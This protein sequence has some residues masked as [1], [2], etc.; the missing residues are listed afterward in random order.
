MWTRGVALTGILTRTSHEGERMITSKTRSGFL[1]LVMVA[2][3]MAP[4]VAS[5]AP[6]T[7]DWPDNTVRV[8]VDA[9]RLGGDTRYH[10]AVEI[11]R[12]G[13][14][15]WSGVDRVIIASGRDA[16]LADPLAAAGLCW[17]YD[18]P[19]LLVDGTS[20]PSVTRTAL[21][22]IVSANTTVT[23]TVIG[24]TRA[25]S[26]AC[27]TALE[28]IVG[29]GQVERP[30]AG[31]D[32]FETAALIAARVS[33]VASES[34]DLQQADAVLIANGTDERKFFDA[35][36]LSAVSAAT[37]A[38]VL[39]VTADK[40]PAATSRMLTGLDPAEVIAGGSE[41]V[42]SARTFAAVGGTDRWY[43]ADRYA[44]AVAVAEHARERGWLTA[45]SFGVAASVPDA[46]VGATY[47]GRNGAPLL[48]TPKD[49][50]VDDVGRYAQRLESEV[51]SATVFG[52][53][54][55]VADA[56]F[57]SLE[58]APARPV[59]TSIDKSG[60]AA[61]YLRVVIKTGVNTS[62][63]SLY[64]GDELIAEKNVSSY[65]TI[66]LGRY[67][68]PSSGAEIRVV[69]TNPEDGATSV[70]KSVKRLAY[71]AATSIVIDKSDF[72]LYWVKGDELVKG[73]PVAIG[74]VGMET[75]IATWKILAKYYTDPSSVYGPRKMRLFRKYG[76]SYVYTAYAI[77]GTNE[78]WVIGT[79][80][81]HGCI[82]MY[83]SDV[84]ELFPQVPLGT[85]VQTRD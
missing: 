45:P 57:K 9:T 63:C 68:V 27:V 73:Y 72:R 59:I 33:E 53:S 21:N 83:N 11:A 39:F 36:A 42:I 52:S 10:T 79:K 55:A 78:P 34:A 32:R 84:L 3:L 56:V 24:S 41:T 81:S 80:A 58:G 43:G 37:G 31:Y 28:G 18:A 6:R 48:Y 44:T 4:G 82:R 49:T 46:L 17:A 69:A 30:F 19:L 8:S 16:S 13:F 22:E 77:H 23:V 76:S 25:V 29:T 15:G 51:T 62:G 5:S 61:K 35:L 67:S 7:V 20:V 74:R 2:A 40:V 14:S 38:P 47:T 50:L 85:L 60:Y 26:S 12:A 70:K 65:V 54:A 64:I 66:D 75:P 1:A 71:P